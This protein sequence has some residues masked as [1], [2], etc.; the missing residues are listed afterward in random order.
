MSP[1]MFALIHHQTQ[2]SPEHIPQD[3]S[4]CPYTSWGTF[5]RT[6]THPG[7][8]DTILFSR[9]YVP[10]HIYELQDI[11]PGH[12]PQDICAPGH[13]KFQSTLAGHIQ[14]GQDIYV[15]VPQDT[16]AYMSWGTSYMSWNTYVLDNMSWGICLEKNIYVLGNII[17]ICPG[18][19]SWGTCL[20]YVLWICLEEFVNMSWETFFICAEVYV[21]GICPEPIMSW[22]YVLPIYPAFYLL[23]DM[24]W[25]YT[26]KDISCYYVLTTM[27]WPLYAGGY[28]LVVY[29][30]GYVLLLCRD[31]YVLTTIC[32]GI[33]PHDMSWWY[34]LK[35]MS[36]YYVL[37]TMSWPLSPERYD[38]VVYPEGYVLL[39]CLD[40]YVLGVYPG[41]YVLVV[42]P[43]ICPEVYVLTNMSSCICPRIRI[44]GCTSTNIWINWWLL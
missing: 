27:S 42:C 19:M 29:P 11:L 36:C 8:K 38:L 43:S 1:L 25:W 17:L 18:D 5:P 37:T 3:I 39:L 24:S 22:A 13:I 28:V 40:D 14:S 16:C 44:Y 26:L 7:H 32:W 2:I 35:D 6:Y 30:E 4:K 12:I 31:E 34:T 23:N 15:K 9:T 21:L 41:W 33:C 10:G 20:W